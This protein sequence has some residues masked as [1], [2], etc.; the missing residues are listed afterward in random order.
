VV[1]EAIEAIEANRT[2]RVAIVVAIA[3]R[4]I[5]TSNSNKDLAYRAARLATKTP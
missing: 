1:I 5:A 4:L 3:T 2:N